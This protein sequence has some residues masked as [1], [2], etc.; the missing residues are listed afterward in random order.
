MIEW[1][2]LGLII[3]GIVLLGVAFALFLLAITRAR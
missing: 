3:G 1:G 2:I